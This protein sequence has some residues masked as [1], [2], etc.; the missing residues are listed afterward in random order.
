MSAGRR[1]RPLPVSQSTF[2][3]G[4]LREEKIR[5]R[6][7]KRKERGALTMLLQRIQRPEGNARLNDPSSVATVGSLVWRVLVLFL[8][9]S[10]CFSLSLFLPLF[11]LAVLS[12]P[13][14]SRRFEHRACEN[15][16]AATIEPEKVD[17]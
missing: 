15:E 16:I 10:R 14:S 12:G 2:C 9:C 6:G 7:E 1:P 13:K 11:P 5:K 17:R 4:C 3:C 8:L